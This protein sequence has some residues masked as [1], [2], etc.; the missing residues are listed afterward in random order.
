MH[1]IDIVSPEFRFAQHFS[2]EAIEV[3]FVGGDNDVFNAA[4][5]FCTLE[6]LRPRDDSA[7]R[8]RSQDNG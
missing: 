5:N 8:R 4:G 1:G 6:C 7:R 3:L 2:R